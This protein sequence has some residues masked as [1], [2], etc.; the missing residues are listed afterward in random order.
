MFGYSLQR[1]SSIHELQSALKDRDDQ[2]RR[3]LKRVDEVAALNRKLEHDLKTTKS[4]MKKF[5]TAYKEEQASHTKTA[6]DLQDAEAR[7]RKAITLNQLSEKKSNECLEQKN[8][9]IVSL[10]TT[11]NALKTKVKTLQQ[12]VLD[13]NKSM[14]EK[15]TILQGKNVDMNRLQIQLK[16][17]KKQLQSTSATEQSLREELKN[18]QATMAEQKE[19]FNMATAKLTMEKETL[20]RNFD[21]FSTV[22]SQNMALIYQRNLETGKK[23]YGEGSNSSNGNTV[24]AGVTKKRKFEEVLTLLN[25]HE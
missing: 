14:K 13:S 7:C 9:R 3:A 11:A 23:G 6:L 19:Q 16:E 17:T 25:G 24:S 20:Q 18:L 10:E 8:A 2:L 21:A 4:T 5:R 22:A 12:D 1:N 15:E